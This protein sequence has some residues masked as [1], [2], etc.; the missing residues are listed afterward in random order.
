[1]L[2][3]GP[4]RREPGPRTLSRAGPLVP[5][6][7]RAHD[8]VMSAS[9]P[10]STPSSSS[11]SGCPFTGVGPGGA[12]LPGDA[13]RA[14]P[15]TPANARRTGPGAD[16]HTLDPG[17]HDDLKNKLDYIGYLGLEQLLSCQRPLSD[18]PHHDELLFIIQH[19]T[20][21]LWFKLAIH[22]VREAMRLVAADQLEASFKILARVKHIQS[23]LL[24]QWSVLATL[25][26]SEYVQFRHVLGPASG[27]QSHQFRL[28]EFLLG[29]KDE[30]LLALFRHK[31]EVHAELE[32]ALR[33][34]S[35]YDEYLR[36][37]ARRGLAV[38]RDMLERDFTK[39]HSESHPGVIA[40][41]KEVYNNPEKYWDEYE[42]AEK[43]V[44][45]DEA[46]ALW[47]FRHTKVVQRIIGWKRGTGG[48]SGVNYL[49]QG[50]DKR[51]F[52]E[53]WDVRT[54]IGT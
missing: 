18:P 38:P 47:R 42:M 41:F 52:P 13:A 25:T 11:G 32:A 17:I 54:E 2:Q 27:L 20:T 15:G 21:E 33:G 37:L 48:T 46:Y 12:P 36:H 6:G 40:V 9:Q 29:G 1:M 7:R 44:D 10:G 35:L 22:E 49:Q 51:Y 19:Q 31:P 3:A 50:V 43:L 8:P 5:G 45:I 53:L 16:I 26:P 39:T 30:R 4:G 24:N 34:P 14:G 28:M 23:Q